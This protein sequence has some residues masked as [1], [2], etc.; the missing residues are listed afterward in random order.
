MIPPHTSNKSIKLTKSNG[1][2]NV[3]VLRLRITYHLMAFD[4]IIDISKT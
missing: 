3:K 4:P 1:E 2:F